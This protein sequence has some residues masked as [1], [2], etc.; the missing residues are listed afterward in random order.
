VILGTLWVKT[1][2]LDPDGLFV[3][4]VLLLLSY[5]M[6]KEIRTSYKKLK[7]PRR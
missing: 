6:A 5:R 7:E 2:T 1:E 4:A 3:V